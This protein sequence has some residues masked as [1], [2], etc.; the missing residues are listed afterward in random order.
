MLLVVI[1]SEAC[2]NLRFGELYLHSRS[3]SDFGVALTLF[4]EATVPG[5]N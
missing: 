5:L 2:V 3:A 1:V 4:T